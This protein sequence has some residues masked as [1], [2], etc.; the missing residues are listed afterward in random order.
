MSKVFVN[1]PINVVRLEGKIGSVK[2]VIYLFFDSHRPCNQQTACSD[3]FARDVNTYF[4]DMFK[5]IK[6]SD[7]TYDFFMELDIDNLSDP[8]S[9]SLTEA[10]NNYISQMIHLF[11]KLFRFDNDANK[12]K[13]N[14]IFENVRLHYLDV[15]VYLWMTYDEE[16]H[17]DDMLETLDTRNIPMRTVKLIN[18]DLISMRDKI[19][20]LVDLFDSSDN[21]IKQTVIKAGSVFGKAD[22]KTLSYLARK[23]KNQYH[24]KNVKDL[25]AEEISGV[26]DFGRNIINKISIA[27]TKFDSYIKSN[28]VPDA[29]EIYDIDSIFDIMGRFY[30]YLTD[31]FMLRRFL[32]KDY[33]TNAIVYSGSWHAWNYIDILVNKFGFKITNVADTTHSIE[34]IEKAVKEDRLAEVF[35]LNG[36]QCSD[37]TSFPTH[38]L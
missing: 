37:L 36:D 33:I 30:T 3:I 9:N 23:M 29:G 31:I 11:R 15:R 5:E 21:A 38:F 13:V 19:Q 4:V 16:K 24:H 18:L 35:P 17:L 27:I 25:L 28:T 32:D 12:I 34:D 20:L 14:E 10:R 1:G 6:D 22:L 26:L 7:V 8:M 2:K